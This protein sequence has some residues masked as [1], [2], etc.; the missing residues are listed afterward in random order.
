[1]NN[2]VQVIPQAP[3][4]K[5]TMDE[6]KVVPNPYRIAEIWETGLS[7]HQIQFTNMPAEA[8][9]KIFNSSG[10]LIRTIYHSTTESLAPSIAKWDLRN[11][12]SQLIAPGVYF[13]SIT[14]VIGNKTGKFF[15]IL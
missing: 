15:I 1:M 14:S 11:N 3:V 5:N 7:D 8:T 12:Y 4:A 13:Y 10:E 2:T 9:I 6:I